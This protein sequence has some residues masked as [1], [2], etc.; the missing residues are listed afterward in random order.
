MK[1]IC[2][3]CG[4]INDYENKNCSSCGR[5]LDVSVKYKMCP[6][7]GKKYMDL[8]TEKCSECKFDLIV[9]GSP[10][11]QVFNEKQKSEIPVILRVLCIIIPII[12][13]IV[14]GIYAIIKEENGQLQQET[15][16]NF[17]IVTVTVQAVLIGAV[18]LFSMLLSGSS[19]E[20]MRQITGK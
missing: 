10:A 1:K 3:D 16:R 15:A 7:C 13:I 9:R 6:N 4:R 8:K 12:G 18:I 2:P 5:E 17:F 19:F 14:A 11:A 20:L